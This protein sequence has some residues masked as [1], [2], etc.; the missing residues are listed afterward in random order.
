MR[1][2]LLVAVGCADSTGSDTESPDRNDDACDV[3]GDWQSLEELECGLSED[4]VAKCNWTISFSANGTYDW[5]YSDVGESGD[6]TCTDG[7][8]SGEAFSSVT[9]TYTPPG[10]LEWDGVDYERRP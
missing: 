8:L 5:F 6:W 3:V 10:D 4:G 7:E 2:L 9:G 1:W